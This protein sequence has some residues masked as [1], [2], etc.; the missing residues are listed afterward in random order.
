[1]SPAERAVVEAKAKTKQPALPVLTPEERKNGWDE[2]SLAAYR[3]ERERES[4][5]GGA[6]LVAGNIVTPFV[7]PRPPL[8]VENMEGWNAHTRQYKGKFR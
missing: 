6:P 3:A 1:M 5:F 2:K 7:R 8:R 4:N